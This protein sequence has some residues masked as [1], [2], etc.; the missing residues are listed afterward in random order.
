MRQHQGKTART[1]L[2]IPREVKFE[3]D[4]T[5]AHDLTDQQFQLN[6]RLFF[7]SKKVIPITNTTTQEGLD[8]LD[9]WEYSDTSDSRC[10]STKRKLL[11]V[12]KTNTAQI[13]AEA[14]VEYVSTLPFGRQLIFP[15]SVWELQYSEESDV[16][17]SVT[18]EELQDFLDR[19]YEPIKSS[20]EDVNQIRINSTAMPILMMF[21]ALAIGAVIAFMVNAPGGACICA[22]GLIGGLMYRVALRLPLKNKVHEF[23]RVLAQWISNNQDPLLEKGIRTRQGHNGCYVLFEANYMIQ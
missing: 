1:N 11:Q 21:V 18:R 4:N 16:T 23:N 7:S 13:V 14:E 9:R 6:D 5:E 10:C 15:G 8:K 2:E 17:Q 3:L 20:V 12:P 19:A 22:A